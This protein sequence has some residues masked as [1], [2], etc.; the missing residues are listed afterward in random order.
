MLAIHPA[1]HPLTHDCQGPCHPRLP[2]QAGRPHGSG[3]L[4]LQR[5]DCDEIL[6]IKDTLIT[7]TS[8]SNIIFTGTD[9]IYTPRSPLLAGVMRQHLIDS[10]TL[11]EHD[12]TVSDIRPGN[13][14][15]ITSAYMINAMLP[16]GAASPIPVGQIINS[17]AAW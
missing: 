10:G 1:R 11:I 15:G 3:H 9:G 4:R 5:G 8:Y 7:D 13:P 2:P 14:L 6:I 16:P 12:L 17:N